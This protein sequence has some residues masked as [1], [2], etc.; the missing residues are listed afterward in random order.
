MKIGVL[1]MVVVGA[2]LG[3]L[4]GCETLSQTPGENFNTIAHT[5]NTN[6]GQIPDDVENALLL[7]RPSW[8]SKKPI[9]N[10]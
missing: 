7:N 6:G 8:L 4:T 10:N 2:T 1:A 3:L 5:I 9:P